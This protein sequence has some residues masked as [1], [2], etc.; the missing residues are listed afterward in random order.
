LLLSQEAV[1]SIPDAVNGIF[2]WHNSSSRTMVLVYIQS[3]TEMSTRCLPGGKGLPARKA[4][5]LTADCI[6]NVWASA[7]HKPR[8]IHGMLQ[9]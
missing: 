6:E 2:N 5:N 4:E 7:T 8:G 3:I 1:A 9:A